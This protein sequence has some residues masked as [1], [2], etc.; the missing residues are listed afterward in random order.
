METQNKL[1]RTKIIY[2]GDADILD[3]LADN[4]MDRSIFSDIDTFIKDS[5][6][7]PGLLLHNAP[8]DLV[9]VILYKAPFGIN[10]PGND[11]ILYADNT[12]YDI[13]NYFRKLYVPGKE[14]DANR[15]IEDV[16]AFLYFQTTKR[17]D[18]AQIHFWG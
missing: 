17:K 12:I 15:A 4:V 18:N 10:E 5:N 3:F 7:K 9:V 11:L 16:I 13:L 6:G 8:P 14:G 2:S 1:K